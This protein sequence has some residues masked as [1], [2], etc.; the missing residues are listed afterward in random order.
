MVTC[1]WML[2]A[3]AFVKQ[4]GTLMTVVRRSASLER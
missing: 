1:P 3:V 2:E 4:T